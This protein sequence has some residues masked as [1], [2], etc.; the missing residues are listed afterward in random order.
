MNENSPID[1]L[2]EFGFGVSIARQMINMMNSTMQSMYVPGQT[3]NQT[4]QKEWFVA[5]DRKPS[6][7]YCED[8]IRKLLIEE[9][10]NQNDLVW[11]AG[12]K[13]WQLAKNVPEILK[14]IIQLPPSL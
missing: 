9:K 6:G 11:T 5:I 4:K 7:P 14:M 2:V 12:M 13:E 8:D 10:M 3:I 1:R